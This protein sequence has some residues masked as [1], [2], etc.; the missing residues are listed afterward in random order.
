MSELTKYIE[1]Q[2]L[3]INELTDELKKYQDLLKLIFAGGVFIVLSAYLAV[4]VR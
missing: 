2:Q 1:E 4:L 3:L